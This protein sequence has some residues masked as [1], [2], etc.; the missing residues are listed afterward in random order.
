MASAL[1]IQNESD[2]KPIT[3]HQEA[4]QMG[5]DSI[6]LLKQNL[7]D[8]QPNQAHLKWLVF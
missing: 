2:G 6:I 1:P 8:I 5:W 4:C 7:A 3:Y